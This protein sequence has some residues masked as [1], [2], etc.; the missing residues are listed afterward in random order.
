MSIFGSLPIEAFT[1]D[2][3]DFT[4]EYVFGNLDKIRF[5]TPYP[6][7]IANYNGPYLGINYPRVSTARSIKFI[8]PELHKKTNDDIYDTIIHET[9]H[10][11]H[12]GKKGFG[13]ITKEEINTIK[14]TVSR[15]IQRGM[16]TQSSRSH[17]LN[18]LAGLFDNSF[19]KASRVLQS[20]ESLSG[21]KGKEE[22]FYDRL[23]VKLDSKEEDSLDPEIS[24]K[25][26]AMQRGLW[27]LIDETNELKV[28]KN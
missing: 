20:V 8:Y 4:P 21:L 1:R 23:F 11:E 3:G 18:S 10:G 25:D 17:A 13:N 22:F 19:R 5:S 14:E 6:T 26:W 12:F 2:R 15:L 9:L 28:L 7:V 27:D 24:D 16:Y